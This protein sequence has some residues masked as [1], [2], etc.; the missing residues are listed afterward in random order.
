MTPLVERRTRR[1]SSHNDEL[2]SQ[3]DIVSKLIL[4][5]AA[6]LSL[7]L[8]AVTAAYPQPA[9]NQSAPTY[10]EAQLDQMLAPIALYPDDLL[11]QVLMAS[12]YPL[13]IVE[14]ERWAKHNE[15]LK[16]DAL[17][18]A[19]QNQTWIRA[20]RRSSRFRRFLP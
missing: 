4:F 14:A 15:Q 8:L 6:L 17:A 7:V 13:E 5:G 12:T 3:G 18:A 20:S 2:L 1:S 16:G 19:L 10:T 11:A 9:A